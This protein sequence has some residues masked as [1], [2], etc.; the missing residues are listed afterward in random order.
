MIKIGPV[1][2]LLAAAIVLSPIHAAFAI[3]T[4]SSTDSSGNS[5]PIADPDDQLDAIANPGA[6]DGGFS[7]DLPPIDMPSGDYAPPAES[8]DDPPLAS[9]V[10]TD[11]SGDQPAN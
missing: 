1:L 10:P 3:T 9:P 5:A 7:I 4:E 11:D 2:A 6:T 8:E